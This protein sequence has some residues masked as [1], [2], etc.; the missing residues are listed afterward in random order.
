MGHF[1]YQL[2]IPNTHQFTHLS[3]EAHTPLVQLPSPRPASSPPPSQ[4]KAAG[5]LA[6]SLPGGA[7]PPPGAA[8]YRKLQG[9]GWAGGAGQG[10]AV[11]CTSK[12]KEAGRRPCGWV[13]AAAASPRLGMHWAHR[14][15]ARSNSFGPS[16]PAST[17][18]CLWPRLKRKNGLPV[19]AASKTRAGTRPAPRVPRPPP[20]G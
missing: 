12:Q 3:P 4:L 13:P 19:A 18:T 16:G 17:A 20:R 5:Q 2:P 8:G 14:H 10:W 15:S 7:S 6:T 11:N 9:K 1:K